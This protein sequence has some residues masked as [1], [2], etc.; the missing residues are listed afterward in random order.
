MR[1]AFA[2]LLASLALSAVLSLPIQGEETSLLQESTGLFHDD[3]DESTVTAE[4][5]EAIQHD[6]NMDNLDDIGES[7]HLS[8]GATDWEKKATADINAMSRDAIG[9]INLGEDDKLTS[10]FEDDVK[11]AKARLAGPKKQVSSESEIEKEADEALKDP[12]KAKELKAEAEKA[13]LD[14]E[15]GAAGVSSFIQEDT[16]S[17]DDDD[18]D[19]G[20][21]DDDERLAL[22]G[23]SDEDVSNAINAAITQ[24]VNLQL[25]S[26]PTD[27]GD[28]DTLNKF[29]EDKVEAQKFLAS[30]PENKEKASAEIQKQL[31]AAQEALTQSQES[32]AQADEAEEGQATK[33]E[34]VKA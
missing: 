25:G 12:A 27:V 8:A 15:S 16:N 13:E 32:D 23:G 21:D 10:K 2:L 9:K 14:L 1:S 30:K 33:E 29:E 31:K 20:D 18:D 11:E 17:N 3:D 34:K 19:L 6:V 22:L 7:L 28:S 4:V 5:T 24:K 26:I